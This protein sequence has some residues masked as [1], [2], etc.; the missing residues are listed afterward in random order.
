MEKVRKLITFLFIVFVISSCGQGTEVLNPQDQESYSNTKYGFSFDYTAGWTYTEF[1]FGEA[2]PDDVYEDPMGTAFAVVLFEKGESNFIIFYDTL[3]S[4]E[5]LS[6]YVDNRRSP[7]DE[8]ISEMLDEIEAIIVNQA[9]WG[10][11]GGSVSAVYA[12]SGNI[13]FTLRIEIVAETAEDAQQTADEF[14]QILN[15]LSVE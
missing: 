2:P 15:T 10:E 9:A 5:T 3:S 11:K 13:V 8:V 12:R 1:P 14:I 7:E 6:E 4:G